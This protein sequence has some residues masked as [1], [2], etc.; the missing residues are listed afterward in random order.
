MTV[1]L[2]TEH[3]LE[4]LCFKGGR[5]GSS[6]FTHVKIPHCWKSRHGSYIHILPEGVFALNLF[7]R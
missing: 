2:L 5:T 4:L 3:N 6:K 7:S 1:T